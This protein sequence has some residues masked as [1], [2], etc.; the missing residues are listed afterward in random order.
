MCHNHA[1]STGL[2]EVEGPWLFDLLLRFLV[3]LGGG[4]VGEVSQNQRGAVFFV[5]I[6]VEKQNLKFAKQKNKLIFEVRSIP[7]APCIWNIITLKYVV[8]SEPQTRGMTLTVCD[9]V[10]FQVD[11]EWMMFICFPVSKWID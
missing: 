7:S 9:S 11:V 10:V 3:I 5:E 6:Q 1:F 4:G 8:H 2:F